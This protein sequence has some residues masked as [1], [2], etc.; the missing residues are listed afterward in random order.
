MGLINMTPHTFSVEILEPLII[1]ISALVASSGFWLYVM[2]KTEGRD[3]VRR[4]VLGLAHDRLMFLS[5][6]YIK[7]GTISKDEYENLCMFL[8]EPY[9]ELLG[10]GTISRLMLEVDRLPIAQERT[11]TVTKE[12]NNVE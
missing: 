4:L 9:K 11:R 8:Y 3:L 2:K 7:K 6:Q 5:M 10:N 1:F 12:K